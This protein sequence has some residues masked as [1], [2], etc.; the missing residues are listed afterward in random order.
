VATFCSDFISLVFSW[1]ESYYHE[2]LLWPLGC[3]LGVYS[4]ENVIGSGFDYTVV[5]MAWSSGVQRLV[6]ALRYAVW[7]LEL[8]LRMLSAMGS[9][10]LLFAMA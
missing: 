3:G 1:R 10:V 2:F 4:C 7:V 6:E 9:I 8:L 5:V